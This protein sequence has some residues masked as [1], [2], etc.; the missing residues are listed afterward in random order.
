MLKNVCKLEHH[1]E[2]QDQLAEVIC[3]VTAIIL[4]QALE[5]ELQER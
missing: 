5:A 3:I 4:C 2:A 1:T